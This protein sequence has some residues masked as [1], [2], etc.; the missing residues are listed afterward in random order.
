MKNQIFFLILFLLVSQV[1]F[2]AETIIG[3]RFDGAEGSRIRI[4]ANKD[5][6]TYEVHELASA[7]AGNGGEFE[8]RL[9][10]DRVIY[11]YILTGHYR[12]E[13]YLEPGREYFLS[14]DNLQIK[15]QFRPF[16]NQEQ[17][18]FRFANADD[19]DLNL[20]IRRFNSGFNDFVMTRFEEI[21]KQRNNAL[22]DSLKEMRGSFA[23]FSDNAY[24]LHYMDY[25]IAS[26]ELVIRSTVK[27]LLFRD[28]FQ[29]KPVLYD[30]V[31]Y[32]YFFNEFFN[33]YYNS[34]RFIDPVDIREALQKNGGYQTMDNIIGADTLLTNERFRELV[35]LKMLFQLYYQPGFNTKAIEKILGT[36]EENSRFR[37][38]NKLATGI[39]EKINKFG[40]GSRAPEILIERE[41]TADFRL[42]NFRGQPVYIGFISLRSFGCLVELDTLDKLQD[43]FGD[44]VHFII[45]AFDEP[46]LVRKY[47]QDEAVNWIL[48]A[49]KEGFNIVNDYDIKTFPQ[50]VLIDERGNIISYPARKPSENI[51]YVLQKMLE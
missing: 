47:R 12:G 14:A 15:D 29:D 46:E 24:F 26:V 10:H 22:I 30:H 28:Y 45:L 49:I 19:S 25:R 16:Y 3:G 39:L 7:L 35:M 42:S 23:E 36:I 20:L 5:Y 38:H 4:L 34:S 37:E 13:I 48:I 9:K 31:E 41:G 50:F 51:E 27:H 11:A 32:M 21:Y 17:L 43:R 1:I 2:S 44:K 8:I 33:H 18:Q 6:I 40:R